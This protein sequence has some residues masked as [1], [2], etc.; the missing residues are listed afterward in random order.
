MIQIRFT[1]SNGFIT[2]LKVRGHSGSAEKGKDLICAAV[3]GI[4]F[5]LCNALDQLTDVKDIVVKDNEIQIHVDH[6]ND[7][8]ETIL[9]TA[10]IQYKTVEENNQDFI[11][12]TNTEV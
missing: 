3:S 5:G 2:D 7:K 6:P 8:I 4:T 10:L 11:Q 9:N 1:K 12:I